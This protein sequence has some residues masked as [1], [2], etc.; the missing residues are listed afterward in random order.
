MIIKRRN[1]T[2]IPT[3]SGNPVKVFTFQIMFSG[4]KL[5]CFCTEMLL[6]PL[7]FIIKKWW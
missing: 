7:D 4:Q 6:R 1:E 3:G 5:N 2:Q